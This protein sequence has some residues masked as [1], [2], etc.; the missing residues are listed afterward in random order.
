MSNVVE[1]SAVLHKFTGRDYDFASS[2]VA[3]WRRKGSLSSSQL[4]WVGKLIEKTKTPPAPA[5]VELA[6]DFARI[7]ALFTGTGLKQPKLYLRSTDGHTYRLS[8][9]GASAKVPGSIN[10]V[11][12]GSAAWQ[13]RITKD[14]VFRPA[15][16]LS[17][18]RVADVTE[19]IKAFGADPEG[20]AAKYGISVGCCCFCAKDLT[21]PR[22]K[23]VGYGPDCAK[24]WKL[25]WGT[26]DYS[27]G[28]EAKVFKP[29]PA[30][31]VEEEEEAFAIW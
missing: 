9:A 25:K 12:K 30:P 3:Q 4:Y 20:V 5:P 24:N 13:G 23:E 11:H 26:K 31:R 10:I 22:S 19:T 27:V 21:D 16:S 18:E 15:V 17:K 2:L 1:L 7:I 6:A 14:G 29:A 8:L 28:T